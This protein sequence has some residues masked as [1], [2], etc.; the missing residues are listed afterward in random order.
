MSKRKNKS[1]TISGEIPAID[2][3]FLYSKMGALEIYEICKGAKWR[4][5]INDKFKFNKLISFS[6][7]E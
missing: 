5:G 1:Y 2:F 7:T 6:L 3:L 4:K